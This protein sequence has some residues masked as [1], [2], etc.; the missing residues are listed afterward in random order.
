MSVINRMLHQE[1]D[2]LVTEEDSL[3]QVQPNHNTLKPFRENCC[4][5][6]YSKDVIH[7]MRSS[8]ASH[9]SQGVATPIWNSR[10]IY[11]ARLS[12][13]KLSTAH[14]ERRTT[15]LRVPLHHYSK[16][17]QIWFRWNLFVR[18]FEVTRELRQR[19]LWE[20]FLDHAALNGPRIQI[21]RTMSELGPSRTI[22]ASLQSIVNQ[23]HSWILGASVLFPSTKPAK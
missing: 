1:C 8:Q 6:V 4:F 19:R 7:T 9:G 16:A 22:L 10:E 11:R 14:Q 15:F 23:P 2:E 21:G 12:T 18:F 3:H 5:S 13:K 20:T 17:C